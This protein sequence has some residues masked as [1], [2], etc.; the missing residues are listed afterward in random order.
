VDPGYD[1]A[2]DLI[3]VDQ[4][5]A[6]M[7][8]LS[9]ISDIQIV[10]MHWGTEYLNTPDENQEYLTQILNEAGAEVIIGTHPHVL[11]PVEIYEGENQQTLVYY[12]LGNFF[13][14]AAGTGTHGRR[15]GP[16]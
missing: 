12:S 9:Q 11:E 7:E 14:S 16:L 1:W 4:I 15:D 8:A 13:K 3:D 6:D 2:I 5:Y 10:S